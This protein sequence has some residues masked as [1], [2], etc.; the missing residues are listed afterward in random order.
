MAVCHGSRDGRGVV[1]K[2]VRVLGRFGRKADDLV[3]FRERSLNGGQHV[4]ELQH[5]GLGHGLFTCLVG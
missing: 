4:G 1:G 2:A 3:V 5:H